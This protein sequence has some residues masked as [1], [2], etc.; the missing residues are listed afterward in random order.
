[1]THNTYNRKAVINQRVLED[2]D[3]YRVDDFSTQELVE[4][5]K[6][7][8]ITRKAYQDKDKQRRERFND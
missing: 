1:M 3:R 7:S 5:T 8:R 6:P 2:L 4:E